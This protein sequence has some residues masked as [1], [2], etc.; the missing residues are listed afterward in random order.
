[1]NIG[2]W[3]KREGAFR[4]RADG[5]W[6]GPRWHLCESIV[7]EDAVVSCGKRMDSVTRSGRKLEVSTLMPLTRMIGQPQLCRQCHR[8]PQV[9]EPFPE[10]SDA[11]EDDASTHD[12]LVP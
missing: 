3:V 9:A 5:T 6:V 10:P 1:M 11:L 4:Q 7:A 12:E 8:E 2:N